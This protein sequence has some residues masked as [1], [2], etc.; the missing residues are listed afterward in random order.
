VPARA[1]I[2]EV[3]REKLGLD[4]LRP[5]QQDAIESVLEGRDTLAVLPTG[6]GKSA[7]YQVAGLLLDGPT[8]VVSP[9]IALQKDQVGKLEEQDIAP[10]GVVNSLG[11]EGERREALA[12]VSGRRIEFLFLAPEQ[13]RS[14]TRLAQLRA[15][16][17]SLLVV[18]EAHCVS[19][20]GHDF[21]PDYLALGAVREALGRPVLLAL[22]ATATPRVRDEIVIRLRMRAPRVV[23]AGFD[24]PNIRLEV[25]RYADREE[26]DREVLDDA[27]RRDRPGIVYVATRRRAEELAG[28]LRGRGVPAVHY[29][30]GLGR[31]ERDRSHEAF[32]SDGATE[33]GVIVATSAFGMGIDKPDVRFVLH[34]DVP[35]SLDAYFQEVGRAGRD[36]QPAD[37]VLFYDAADLRLRRFFAASGRVEAAHVEQ[38][39][40]VLEVGS[41]E[42]A[43]LRER[44]G[45]SRTRLTGAVAGL[46]DAGA[47]ERTASGEVRLRTRRAERASLAA[48]AA[49]QRERRR[50]G[51]HE[52]VEAMRAYA[53]ASGCRRQ[54]L[55]GYFGE[56]HPG[57][58]ASC[59]NCRRQDALAPRIA[60]RRAPTPDDG[61]P[62]GPRE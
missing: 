28:A 13:L 6:S 62:H 36:G 45:L 60:A 8:I 3:A 19:E 16:R 22:T 39:L 33:P 14:R 30:G 24:R 44:T 52:R 34:G 29:H 53:E 61:A 15:A 38:V 32:V 5:G 23:V 51:E 46:E 10:A 55:L 27:A 48:E 56:A 18:D 57:S 11:P 31:A 40:A 49:K 42:M 12:A 20:W 35:G 7:I 26:K 17:P 25:R 9:L 47:V 59:D 4:E 58:C 41:A 43:R 37:A 54:L 1:G 21:R 2:R 50:E